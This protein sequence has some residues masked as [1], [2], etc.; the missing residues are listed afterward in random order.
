MT[1]EDI[2]AV[3]KDELARVAPEIEFDTIDPKADVRDEADI[4]SIDFL[5]LLTALHLRLGVD[6]PEADNAK[7]VTLD[8]A[9]AYLEA[10]LQPSAT[11]RALQR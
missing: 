1:P 5:N 11:G 2:R 10:R 7:L 6:I 4:D 8:G 9:V 3:L